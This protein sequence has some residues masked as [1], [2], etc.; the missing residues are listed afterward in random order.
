MRAAG[1]VLAALAL[2]ACQHTPAA[3]EGAFFQGI[4]SVAEDN[5]EAN[6]YAEGRMVHPPPT[7][8]IWGSLGPGFDG[9]GFRLRI[10]GYSGPTG[11]SLQATLP[12]DAPGSAPTDVLVVSFPDAAGRQDTY[13]GSGTLRV[14][15]I[16]PQT[17]GRQR[18]RARYEGRVCSD[19]GT[20]LPVVG[21]FAFTRRAP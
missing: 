13:E 15:E 5:G 10:D 11:L 8:G 3:G 16:V 1:A 20:C 7:F 9:T 6:L 19:A 17:D 12:A 4:V 2:A 14:T 21:A 18:V